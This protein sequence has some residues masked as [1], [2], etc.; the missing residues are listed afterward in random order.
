MFGEGP[1]LVILQP[2]SHQLLDWSEPLMADWYNELAKHFTVVRFDTRLFG[3]SQREDADLTYQSVQL[4]LEAVVQQVGFAKFSILGISGLGLVAAAYAADNPDRVERIVL[5][6]TPKDGS[7]YRQAPR[8]R[9][10][11][12][13]LEIDADLAFEMQ[14]RVTF[15]LK[16]AITTARMDHIRE[17]MNGEGLGAYID[18]SMGYQS[19]DYPERV[20]CPALAIYP[21]ESS[22]IASRH[23]QGLAARIPDCE[24]V[25]TEAGT[26]PYQSDSHEATAALL[27]DFLLIEP[28]KDALAAEPTAFQTIMFTDLESSTALT[29]HV[30]DDAAQGVLH[31]HN[32][33]VRRSLDQH[34]GRE[35]KHTGDGI[36]AAFPSAVGA[37]Q[38]ALQIQR[39]L[40]GGEVRVRIG[41]NAGE[42]IAEDGDFFGTA[43][44]LA[45]RICDRADPG[46]ILVSRVVADLCAGKRIAFQPAGDAHMKGFAE[47][48]FLFEATN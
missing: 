32:G 1:P 27:T 39:D 14:A 28:A 23:A 3:L 22:W 16:A 38:S 29:Q 35:V 36:M 40:A 12:A 15:G 6:A 48:I 9:G 37:V 11:L 10:I 46:Q 2:F 19:G 26:Y 25:Q 21:R 47:P 5:W 34:G 17:T 20:Q 7:D 24:F 30:G 44:Q 42:P 43:V 4:D 18:A 8:T 31:G 41:L 45:A 33:A 13:L